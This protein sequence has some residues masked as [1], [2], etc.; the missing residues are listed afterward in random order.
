MTFYGSLCQTTTY[1]PLEGSLRFYPENRFLAVFSGIAFG[2]EAAVTRGTTVS[3]A[4]TRP[5]GI[6]RATPGYGA[7]SIT[8]CK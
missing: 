4:A 5:T 3:A 8:A 2:P 6:A 1:D 7:F